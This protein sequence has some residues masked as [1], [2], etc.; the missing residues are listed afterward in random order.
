M[1][2]QFLNI[3][4]LL[5]IFQN[6]LTWDNEQFFV[7]SPAYSTRQGAEW[8]SSS[9]YDQGQIVLHNGKYYQ[10]QVD[11]FNNKIYLQDTLILKLQSNLTMNLSRTI[12]GKKWLMIYG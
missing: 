7:A 6:K 12:R 5:T 2:I 10:C 3:M 4:L 11:D 9:T 8:S 1:E